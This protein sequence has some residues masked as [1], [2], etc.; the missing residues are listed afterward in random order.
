MSLWR[1]PGS[2]VRPPSSVTRWGSLVS[3][4][5]PV[6][7]WRDR[8]GWWGK[9]LADDVPLVKVEDPA[10]HGTTQR[11]LQPHGQ[12]SRSLELLRT[13][14]PFAQQTAANG[15]PNFGNPL[16]PC[17]PWLPNTAASPTRD[18]TSTGWPCGTRRPSTCLWHDSRILPTIRQHAQYVVSSCLDWNWG[19]PSMSCQ[20]KHTNLPPPFSN[21]MPAMCVASSGSFL[22]VSVSRR[23]SLLSSK[24]L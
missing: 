7:W 21:V 13:F 10:L 1:G 14:L 23:M 11:Q 19:P 12:S 6:Q 16:P 5:S 4:P 9:Y 20:Y 24:R 18:M 2:Q 22:V 17:A 8:G 3:S 15:V